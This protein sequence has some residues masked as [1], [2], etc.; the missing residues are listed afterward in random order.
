LASTPSRAII[1]AKPARVN[2]APRSETNTNGDSRFS[3]QRPHFIAL[4]RMH[5]RQSVLNAPDVQAR[6]AAQIDLIPSQID[7]LRCA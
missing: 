4:E 6:I 1:F 3:P 2:G 5:T 7:Q